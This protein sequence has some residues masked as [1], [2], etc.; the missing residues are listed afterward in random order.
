LEAELARREAMTAERI[1]RA[2][3]TAMAEVRS[4]AADAAVEAAEALL[5]QRLSPADQARLVVEGAKELAARFR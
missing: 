1:Q 4:V 5:R 2:E 3:A